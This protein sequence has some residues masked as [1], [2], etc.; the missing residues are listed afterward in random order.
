MKEPENRNMKT[1]LALMAVLVLA[2]VGRAQEP[3]KA[4]LK[5][6]GGMD[7]ERY[8]GTWHEVARLPFRFQDQCVGDVTATYTMQA[9]GSVLVVNR[10]R[11]RDGS[12]S[13]A[14]GAARKADAS[15]PSTKLKV[16]FAPAWLSRLPFVWG[17][18]WVIELAPDYS[19]VAVGEPGRKYLW[20]L[21]RT[22][23]ME[24]ATLQRVLE[25][26]REHDYD[27]ARLI[28]TRSSVK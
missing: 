10:C 8:M 27:L 23:S 2:A 7:L 15:G 25:K 26:V 13:E 16:R 4:P 3:V 19:Y 11:T 6:V 22:P 1:P 28:R 9:D 17:D 21:S 20:V 5:A 14:R 12:V 18:Y 24:E